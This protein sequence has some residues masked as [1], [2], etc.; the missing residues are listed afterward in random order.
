MT[1]EDDVHGSLS[2]LPRADTAVTFFD[3]GRTNTGTC[4][5]APVPGPA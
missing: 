4:Q 2:A 5:G 3:T 1:I